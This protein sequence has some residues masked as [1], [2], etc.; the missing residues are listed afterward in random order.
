MPSGTPATEPVENQNETS[1]AGTLAQDGPSAGMTRAIQSILVLLAIVSSISIYHFAVVERTAQRFALLDISEVIGIKQLV[2]ADM[3]TR[4]GMTDK[5]REQIYD[6]VASFA[7]AM[8][9]AVAQIQ[10]ECACTLLVRSAVVKTT[11]AEDLT[12]LLKARLGLD[13]SIA[14]LT[15]SIRSHPGAS[16]STLAPSSTSPLSSTPTIKP[17]PLSGTNDPDPVKQ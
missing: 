8:E 12:P 13:Q 16:P 7:K 5:D 15:A 2:I 1:D 14:D 10:R 11:A 4:P 9:Q 17:G 6:S 3:A